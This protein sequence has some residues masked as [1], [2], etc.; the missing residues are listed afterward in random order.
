MGVNILAAVAVLVGRI[1]DT[2]KGGAS[3]SIRF[4][5]VMVSVGC[6]LPA[7]FAVSTLAYQLHKLS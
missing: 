6:L 7:I 4:G 5:L 1:A 2:L 3:L